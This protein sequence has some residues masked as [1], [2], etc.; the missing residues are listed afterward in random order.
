[1]RSGLIRKDLLPNYAQIYMPKTYFEADMTAIESFIKESEYWII[2]YC[3]SSNADGIQIVH[4]SELK[5]LS[6]IFVDGSEKRILQHYITPHLSIDR[7]KYHIRVLVLLLGEFNVY[8]YKNLRVLLA[9]EPYEA[10][11]VPT[12]LQN[13]FVHLTN[14]SVNRRHP[15]YDR[16]RQ[17]LA[18]DD[19]FKGSEAMQDRVLEQIVAILRH[20]FVELSKDRRRFFVLP[21]CYE[22]FG[23]DFMLDDCEKV[24]LLEANPDPSLVQM[25]AKTSREI[26]GTNVL[27][28]VP[29]TFKQVLDGQKA[30][31]MQKLKSMLMTTRVSV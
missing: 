17:N 28:S 9:F 15:E 12:N 27:A 13:P 5:R 29:E 19:A 10:D 24:W 8:Y 6:A 30:Q 16:A 22:L 11:C 7:K 21:N 1:M 23:F 3:D 14:Q 2:K 20:V 25:Y 26:L 31:A 4:Q 18:F